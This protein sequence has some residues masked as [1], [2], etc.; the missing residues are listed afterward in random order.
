VARYLKSLAASRNG[1]PRSTTGC[2]RDESP[3]SVD[4]FLTD[5]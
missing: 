4:T 3:C 1:E 2:P 5:L